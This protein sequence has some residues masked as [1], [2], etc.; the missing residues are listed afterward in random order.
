[1]RWFRYARRAGGQPLVRAAIVVTAKSI[2]APR[3]R[4]ND[5]RARRAV[6]T[7]YPVI[8]NFRLSQTGQNPGLLSRVAVDMNYP[9]WVRR[10]SQK[11]CSSVCLT[12]PRVSPGHAWN[13]IWEASMDTNT[14]L[15]DCHVGAMIFRRRRFLGLSQWE[16]A[17]AVGATLSQIQSYEKG[18]VRV[19]ASGLQRLRA[20]LEVRPAYFFDGFS[21]EIRA[22]GS[23]EKDG[24]ATPSV[25]LASL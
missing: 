15:I 8:A 20:A 16:I 12:R 13:F 19:N 11:V 14:N 25:A 4:A 9:I 5:N 22:P 6:Q 7:L 21:V 18:T 2:F 3:H 23:D 17:E 1:V 10:K 24:A